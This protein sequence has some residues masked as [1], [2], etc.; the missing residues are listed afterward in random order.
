[1]KRNNPK[2]EISWV[3]SAPYRELIESNPHIDHAIVVDCLTDWIKLVAHGTFDQVVDLH[4][5]GR[6]CGHCNV[7]LHKRT[8]D[9]VAITADNYFHY[10]SLLR[11]FSLLAGLPP[12]ED[13]PQIYITDAAKNSI[14]A[15]GLPNRF[16][17]FHCLSN[18]IQKNW[19]RSQW[20]ELAKVLTENEGITIVEVG[21]DPVL[22]PDTPGVI[23]ICGNASLLE[24][25]EIIRRST[26]FVGIDS[27][28]AHLANA[29]GTFGI[30]LMGGLGP[31]TKYNPFTGGYANGGNALLLR[32]E[33]GP[34]SELPFSVVRDAVES[35]LQRINGT[36]SAATSEEGL[37]CH[38]ACSDGEAQTDQIRTLCSST[39]ELPPRLIAFYL[40]QYHPIPE[41]DKN[42]G[43]GFTEWRNVGRARP[44]FE[45][46]YQ[47]RLPGEFGYYDLRIP[48]V[49]EEQAALAQEYGVHGFCYY[50]YW[51]QGK[52]VLERPIDTMLRTKRPNYPFCFCWANENWTRRWD[53]M[54]SEIL[55]AQNHTYEDDVKFIR[56]FLPA[57][58]D[59][60]YI[61]VNGRPLLLIYRTELFPDPLRTAETWREELRKAGL[62]DP[63]L[64]RCEGFD[65]V[66]S[67]EEIGFDAAYE[68]PSFFLPQEL[69]YEDIERL[70]V[71]PE[72]RGR[73][74]D[75][76][77]IQ[78]FYCNREGVAHKRFR[79]PMLAWDNTPRHGKNALIFHNVTIEAYEN[80][81]VQTLRHTNRQFNG[82]ERLVFLHAW[83]E[84]A[85]GTHLEPDLR[86]GR[87]FLEATKR[88]VDSVRGAQSR[89]EVESRTLKSEAAVRQ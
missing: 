44:F 70:N 13:P 76:R 55:L 45:E 40:P 32:N 52:R 47:P 59:Q 27:G 5:N 68:V 9:D 16:I 17:V 72:F 83:N 30:V 39:N 23:D 26:L 14:D 1:L 60:R 37:D 29:V 78:E 46:Q 85:E 20:N 63:Y 58:D 74:Y 43:K 56:H 2:A 64:V 61:R 65:S 51:F 41:N 25:A 48:S 24:I 38:D 22:G 33:T 54:E 50:L 31:F 66:T 87:S 49:L 86:Y 35:T 67:P 57:F 42:W 19:P 7:P 73:I 6:I 79:M 89:L 69:L 10:G 88:A 4:L 77:K 15:L 11:A 80:W 21:L 8:R 53:G 81:V 12:L 82:E 34:A 75:Y 28:P 36:E 18:Y 84:W 62:G 71:S 3:V